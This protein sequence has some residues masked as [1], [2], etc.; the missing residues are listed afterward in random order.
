MSDNKVSS[1]SWLEAFN[2]YLGFLC[3]PTY[4]TIEYYA[5]IISC[6]ESDSPEFEQPASVTSHTLP[7]VSQRSAMHCGVPFFIHESLGDLQFHM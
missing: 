2:I 3:N 6:F 7:R 1:Q 4:C 5:E